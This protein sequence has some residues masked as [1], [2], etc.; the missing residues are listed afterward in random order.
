[1]RVSRPGRSRISCAVAM[2][3]SA[4]LASASRAAASAGFRI[5]T[6]RSRSSRPDA[7]GEAVADLEPQPLGG[8]ALEERRA[9]SGEE[10]GEVLAGGERSAEIAAE[11]RLAPRIEAEEAQDGGRAGDRPAVGGRCRCGFLRWHEDDEVFDDR[12]RGAEAL[13]LVGAGAQAGEERFVEA[14]RVAGDLI[15]RGAGGGVGR[16]TKAR[17]ALSLAR[18]TRP[19]RRRRAPRGER[20]TELRGMAGEEAGGS[21]AQKAQAGLPRRGRGPPVP[22]RR[23][24]ADQPAVVEGEDAVGDPHDLGAV[25]HHQHR[26]AGPAGEPVEEVQHLEPGLDI[27]IA[28]GLVGEQERRVGARARATPRAAARRPRAGRESAGAAARPTS[29]SSAGRAPARPRRRPPVSS[30]G[31][32]R[33]S[34]TVSV[35]TRL[36]NWKTK[37]MRSRRNS[38]R[39]P[40]TGARNSR[41]S[42]SDLARSRL[43]DAGKQIQQRRLPGAAAPEQ[44]DELP[45]RDRA[46]DPVEYDPRPPRLD[47]ASLHRAQLDHRDRRGHRGTLRQQWV[48]R[49]EGSASCRAQAFSAFDATIRKRSIA[50]RSWSAS[51]TRSRLRSA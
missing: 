14:V 28:G 41:P 16:D 31:S 17:R 5:P 37:P 7:D 1:M 47:E 29:S 25:G 46:R 30:S 2:S 36:K 8:R 9:G 10:S 32:S 11:R 12:R 38:V 49:L 43:V 26:L 20:Q 21:R 6:S 44:D 51:T 35:G 50:A 19:R 40:R 34:S 15:R 18:S 45:G 3:T 23:G 33:F 39:A 27:E 24:E 42:S 48:F 4:R 13:D 22:L